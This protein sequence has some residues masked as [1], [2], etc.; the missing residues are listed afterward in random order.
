V[1]NYFQT[2]RIARKANGWFWGSSTIATSA[3]TRFEKEFPLLDKLLT[4][5]NS[6]ERWE[7]TIHNAMVA[8]AIISICDNFPRKSANKIVW[9]LIKSLCETYP[10]SEKMEASMNFALNMRDHGES[11]LTAFGMWS[12]AEIKGHK[13]TTEELELIKPLGLLITEVSCMWWQ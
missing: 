10:D 7:T 2:R 3:L 13:P 9:N 4:D 5:D 1:L 11:L 12:L 8:C 6:Q